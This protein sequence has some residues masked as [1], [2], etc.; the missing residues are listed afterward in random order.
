MMAAQWNQLMPMGTK[1]QKF[2][3]PSPTGSATTDLSSFWHVHTSQGAG[4]AVDI[5]RHE[6]VSSSH[7]VKSE[8]QPVF[9]SY[10]GRAGRNIEETVRRGSGQPPVYAGKVRLDMDLQGQPNASSSTSTC[11]AGEVHL[12]RG[13]SHSGLG[14]DPTAVAPQGSVAEVSSRRKQA[15][16][17]AFRRFDAKQ[18][19]WVFVQE[20]TAALQRFSHL[21]LTDQQ[22]LTHCLTVG[23]ASQRVEYT[24]FAAYYHL[25]GSNIERDRDFEDM[26][27]HHWGFAEISDIM[28]DMKNKFAMVGL[29]YAFRR[30]LEKG[31]SPELTVEAF[32]E[33]IGQVGITYGKSEVE[34]IFGAFDITGG[35]SGESKSLEVLRLTAHLTGAPRPGTP[36]LPI[37]GSAH[38]SEVNSQPEPGD[39]G[40]SSLVGHG[41]Q[42]HTP[43]P[44]LQTEQ[45]PEPRLAPLE[46][47]PGQLADRPD[48]LPPL[49]PPEEDQWG[50]L[51]PVEQ[52]TASGEPPP[53]PPERL[54]CSM[55]AHASLSGRRSK[56]VPEFPARAR[57][58]PASQLTTA[59][60][61]SSPM[62]VCGPHEDSPAPTPGSAMVPRGAGTRT[63]DPIGDMFM[64]RRIEKLE[65]EI[66]KLRNSAQIDHASNRAT[67]HARDRD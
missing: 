63:A 52:T 46:P 1:Q 66:G 16:K 25:L 67:L 2:G 62:R 9:G 38:F 65:S 47:E 15:V 49:A 55:T 17:A 56:H 31:G 48:V 13:S 8:Q 20:L 42:M 19:G 11:G 57:P 14:L 61:P 4:M 41:T 64:A 54:A 43:S 36:V 7:S 50:E 26:L 30:S 10:F 53:A 34:R 58:M 28:D 5:R 27:R 39:V 21:S 23:G 40:V 3:H 37:P 45:L 59:P 35:M 6:Q 33:A 18:Q 60:M 51:A 22:R 29:A 12:S 32:Q 44:S 24:Q